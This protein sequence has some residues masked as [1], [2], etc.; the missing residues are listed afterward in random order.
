[1]ATPAGKW[2]G[3]YRAKPTRQR[4][5]E[6]GSVRRTLWRALWRAGS[7]LVFGLLLGV[8]AFAF[9]IIEITAEQH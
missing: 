8:L 4:Q 9:A 5:G 7:A 2:V 6:A 1:M 3:G